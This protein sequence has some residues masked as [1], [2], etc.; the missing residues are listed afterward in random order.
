[1][2]IASSPRHPVIPSPGHPGPDPGSGD[3]TTRVPKC[4][5]R[6]CGLPEEGADIG[7]AF[8]PGRSL[9]LKIVKVDYNSVEE[10]PGGAP[11]KAENSMRKKYTWSDSTVI[12]QTLSLD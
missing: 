5:K 12:F 3:Y 10:A 9:V 6:R 11:Q 2:S 7:L 8:E 1:M 4:R